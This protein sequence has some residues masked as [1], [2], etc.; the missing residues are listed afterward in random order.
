MSYVYIFKYLALERFQRLICYSTLRYPYNAIV[1]DMRSNQC[2]IVFFF[3][4]VRARFFFQNS[5]YF[6]LY[7]RAVNG[8]D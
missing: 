2:K 8:V 7:K 6:F 5:S 4:M 1:Y 3:Q